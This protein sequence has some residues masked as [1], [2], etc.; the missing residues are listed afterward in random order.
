MDKSSSEFERGRAWRIALVESRRR[1]GALVRV[2]LVILV[3]ILATL[4]F[5]G[6]HLT[7]ECMQSF[8]CFERMSR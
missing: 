1:A 7:P 5:T 8:V 3:T 2:G 6:H 4:F